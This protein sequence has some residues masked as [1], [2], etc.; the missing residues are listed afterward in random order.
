MLISTT[1]GRFPRAWLQP[2]RPLILRSSR[3]LLAQADPVGVA[4]F[5]SNLH[6]TKTTSN[7]N[8]AISNKE[9]RFPQ[10]LKRRGKANQFVCVIDL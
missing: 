2:P 1:D 7:Y 3:G 6:L 8:R 4:V 9:E 10:N 5:R